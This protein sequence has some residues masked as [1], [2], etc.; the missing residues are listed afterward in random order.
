VDCEALLAEEASLPAGQ[1]GGGGQE[2]LLILSYELEW[3]IRK[4][5]PLPEKPA[6]TEPIRNNTKLIS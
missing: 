5:L 3:A 1:A 2:D 4:P 6:I